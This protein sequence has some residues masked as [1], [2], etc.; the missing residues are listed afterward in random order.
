MP[1]L[2]VQTLPGHIRSFDFK[3]ERAG[4]VGNPKTAEYQLRAGR[5]G[6]PKTAEYQLRAGRLGNPK[7]A[8]YQLRAGR[9]GNPK[10]TEYQLR[11][12]RV[13]N[14]KSAEYQSRALCAADLLVPRCAARNGV[15]GGYRALRAR[16]S[17]GIHQ[18]IWTGL[19]YGD[20]LIFR[21]H[22]PFTLLLGNSQSH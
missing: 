6:N 12:G 20:P 16:V 7:S 15:M 18:R 19:C 2:L 11:A 8:E 13:G 1:L 4:R 14:P 17:S 10:T 5:V 21:D 22:S 3:K 9:V